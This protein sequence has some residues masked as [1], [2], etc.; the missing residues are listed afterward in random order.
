MY[1]T[2]SS[3]IIGSQVDHDRTHNYY[4]LAD[5]EPMEWIC[6]CLYLKKEKEK[7]CREG[8]SSDTRG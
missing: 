4:V 6:C 8:V 3:S 5:D 7:K 2:L 1:W